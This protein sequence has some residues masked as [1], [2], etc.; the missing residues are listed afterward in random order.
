MDINGEITSYTVSL[1]AISVATG[2]SSNSRIMRR[3]I[4]APM[5]VNIACIVGGGSNVER[6]FS[7]DPQNTSLSV[8]DLSESLQMCSRY[9]KY[10][11]FITL[12]CTSF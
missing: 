5:A 9:L 8:D 11:L 3:E 4:S 1:V 10:H 7:V 12:F 2:S 6:N